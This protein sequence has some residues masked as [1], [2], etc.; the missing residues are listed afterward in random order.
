M[1]NQFSAAAPALGYIYQ[2][3]YALYALLRAIKDNPKSTISVE[4]LDDVAFEKD[5]T[6]EELIQLKHTLYA[7]QADLS[8]ASERLWKTLRIWSLKLKEEPASFFD[9]LLTLVTTGTTG[10]DSAANKLREDKNRDENKALKILRHTAETSKNKDNKAAYDAFLS[11][12]FEQQQLLLSRTRVIDS[13]PNISGVKDKILGEFR[14]YTNHYEALLSRLE[15]WWFDKIVEHLINTDQI[16]TISGEQLILKIRELNEQLKD[17]NLPND[18]PD[19]IEM[20]ET[21]LSPRERIFVEQLRLIV[22]GQTRI[23][24]A[25]GHYYRAFQQ[26]TK[27]LKDGL[28]F[29]KELTDYENYLVSE[30]RTQFEIMRENLNDLPNNDE[31]AKLGKLLFDSLVETKGLR[32][33]RPKFFDSGFSKGTFHMLAN[34]LRVGWHSEFKERLT[35][36]LVEGAKQAS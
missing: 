14:V 34:D 5:G 15:G 35:H 33:I 4:R 24:L 10:D 36:L 25:I 18:F 21:E 22:V 23:R 12:T 11:L 7:Q 20:D 6:S 2:V 28:V 13:H 27:W 30:W 9:L 32:P 16:N 26:R 29:P 8:N 19:V 1:S 31:V 17:D 3:R